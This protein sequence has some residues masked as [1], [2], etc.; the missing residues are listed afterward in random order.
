MREKIKLDN[1]DLI[2]TA[3]R[4]KFISSPDKDNLLSLVYEAKL[5]LV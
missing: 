3:K 5:S 2:L 4:E 1:K